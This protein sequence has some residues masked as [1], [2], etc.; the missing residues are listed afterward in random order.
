MQQSDQHAM[1]EFLDRIRRA[2]DAGDAVAYGDQFA[3][4]ASYV[5]FLGDA[6]FGRAEITATHHEV[7]T[8][9]QRGTRMVVKPISVSMVDTRTVVVVTVGGVGKGRTIE[10]DKYQTYT[11][12]NKNGRWECVA[13]QNTEMSKRA[14]KTHNQ[15]VAT[16]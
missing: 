7:F 16:S 8:K 2:W 5:I 14:K 4:D 13:F 1:N 6:L 10:Y 3:E 9:W 11:L 15:R 12:R